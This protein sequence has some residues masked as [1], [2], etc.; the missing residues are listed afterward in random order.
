MRLISHL[1]TT[2]HHDTMPKI[3]DDNLK[4]SSSDRARPR[5][6]RITPDA[7]NQELF[8]VNTTLFCACLSARVLHAEVRAPRLIGWLD[9]LSVRA[10]ELQEAVES[11]STN[12]KLSPLVVDLE[13]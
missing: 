10:R 1:L 13:H 11:D 9:L 12:A 6:K 5:L 7:F 2:R 3:I 4:Y 8:R